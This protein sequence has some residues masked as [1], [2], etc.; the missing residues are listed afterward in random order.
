MQ[1]S[2][3]YTLFLFEE[4]KHKYSPKARVEPIGNVWRES[5]V[6]SSR[7]MI[8]NGTK[9][10]IMP[11]EEAGRVEHQGSGNGE[12][13]QGGRLVI[14]QEAQERYVDPCLW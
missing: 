7:G 5:G 4:Q 8:P 1:A 3:R 12:D 6:G 11:A 10:S 13:T 2:C 9:F 14:L